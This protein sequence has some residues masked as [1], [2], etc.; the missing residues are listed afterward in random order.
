[1]KQCNEGAKPLQWFGAQPPSAVQ[2]VGGAP[3]RVQGVW[4]RSL[5]RC[6]GSSQRSLRCEGSGGG[7]LEVHS[8]E[9]CITDNKSAIDV[10]DARRICQM[11]AES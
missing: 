10:G 2:R 6:R 4:G 9:I 7:A 11:S 8:R 5:P 1:M 3:P